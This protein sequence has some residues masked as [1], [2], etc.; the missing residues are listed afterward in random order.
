METAV[1]LIDPFLY[2]SRIVDFK[3]SPGEI[4]PHLCRYLS[5]LKN[6]VFEEKRI[7]S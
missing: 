3:L 5:F 6:D 4:L 1:E 2:E 7:Q